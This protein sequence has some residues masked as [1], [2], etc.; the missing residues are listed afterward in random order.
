MKTSFNMNLCMYFALMHLFMNQIEIAVVW[1][2]VLKIVIMYTV[3]P[4]LHIQT[5]FN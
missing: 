5:G 4:C 2:L 3:K 1:K